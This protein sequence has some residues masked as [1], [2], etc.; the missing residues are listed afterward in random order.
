MGGRNMMN[1]NRLFL[2]ASLCTIIL[3]FPGYAQITSW[4][5]ANGVRHFSNVNIS[6]EH[7]TIKKM[8]EYKT[9]PPDEEAEHSRDRFQILQ[10]YKEDRENEEKQ[11][12]L[13]KKVR[14]ADEKEKELQVAA[15]KADR[16][17]RKAC[18]E[19]KRNLEDLRHLD[20]ADYD[21][22]GV[23]PASCPDKRWIGSH[24]RLFDNL[25]E[26]TERRNKSLKSAYEKAVC[27]QE[28]EIKKFCP[29]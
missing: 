12:E 14:E 24:G 13:E 5:D 1:L 10:L 7:K 29:Q 25:E 2:Y 18:T 3:A 9:E 28:E 26:C 4:T 20:W 23:K 16:D 8:K 21:A 17:R 15:E 11:K 22:P 27:Q 6:G 19:H